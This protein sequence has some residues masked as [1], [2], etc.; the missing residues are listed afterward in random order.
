M[1][2]AIFGA[3]GKTGRLLVQ[4][5]LAEGH[6]VAALA[7]DPAKMALSHPRLRVIPGAV[8]QVEA[9][10][11]TLRDADVV[12][13]AMGSGNAT[14][15]TFWQNAIAAMRR[16]G[17]S[18]IVSLVGASVNEPGD[19]RSI[20][21]TILLGITRLL[22]PSSLEDGHRHAR[23][24]EG[25]ELAYTFVRPPRLTDGPAT[26]RVQ[27]GRLQLGPT[28]SISR[29]DLASFMLRAACDGL[30]VREAPMVANAR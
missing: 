21:R 24:L 25:T 16:A 20:G 9:V 5:A 26:G 27:H 17:V 6:D 12:V 3:T 30:Y 4:Q 7:R 14:L 10:Q 22:A 1:N 8:D 28:S 29:A 11:E 19:P 13:S 18:R 2:L 23:Q 15:T